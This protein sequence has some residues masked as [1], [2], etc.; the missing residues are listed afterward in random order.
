M[1]TCDKHETADPKLAATCG[2]FCRACGLY[3][4]TTEDTDRLPQIAQRFGVSEDAVRCYGC[5]SDR[6]GPF[7]QTC[8]MIAC[9][10]E[11][12]I[13]FCGACDEYPC[14]TLKAFQEAMPH[15]LDLWPSLERIQQVGYEQWYQEML[16]DYSCPGCGT[17]NGCYNLQC[18]NCGAEASCAFVRRHG[19]KIRAYLAKQG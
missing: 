10:A 4:A 19:D 5:H 6:R 9:A 8:T 12:G 3:L 17:I 13:E 11:K 14:E 16:Q 1:G 15:R 2:L 7:C 18:R